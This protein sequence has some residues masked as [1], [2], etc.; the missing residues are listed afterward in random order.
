MVVVISRLGNF[1]FAI[2]YILFG[3][4]SEIIGTKIEN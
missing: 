4:Y 2:C 1:N 3:I